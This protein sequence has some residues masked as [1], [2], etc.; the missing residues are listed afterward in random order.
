MSMIDRP[1]FE[2][3]TCRRVARACVL[4][5]I[6]GLT[7]YGF[8]SSAVSG[9]VTSAIIPLPQGVEWGP[10]PALPSGARLAVVAGQPGAAGLYAIRVGFPGGLQ[11]M[12]HSHPDD[13]LYTVLSGE[14][15]IGLGAAFD[16]EELETF[17]PGSVYVLQAGT[18]HFHW[19]QAGESVVQIAGLGP[20]ATNH[21]DPE[22]DPR[23]VRVR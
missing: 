20:T 23:R 8:T 13:R 6:V 2:S 10:N 15:S 7:L 1:A 5:T 11:V 14:W 3:K 22:D 16:P 4:P 19:A 21:V 17:S 12:P 18:A 9:Q